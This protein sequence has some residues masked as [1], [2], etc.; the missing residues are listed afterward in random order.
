MRLC[1]VMFGKPSFGCLRRLRGALSAACRCSVV[2]ALNLNIDFARVLAFRASGPSLKT[3]S[4]SR[5][6]NEPSPASIAAFVVVGLPILRDAKRAVVDDANPV[7]LVF[8]GARAKWSEGHLSSFFRYASIARRMS[9]ATDRP[10][11]SAAEPK[12]SSMGSGMNRLVRFIS[13]DM[14][15]RHTAQPKGGVNASA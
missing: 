13:D 9:S 4:A 11:L 7:G 2:G 6:I 3:F 14:A 1:A 15:D 8:E 10:V 12:R 5:A